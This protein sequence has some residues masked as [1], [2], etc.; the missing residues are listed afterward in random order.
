MRP[1]RQL[2]TLPLKSHSLS[3][4]WLLFVVLVLRGKRP[5]SFFFAF[6]HGKLIGLA[7]P[8]STSRKFCLALT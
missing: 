3:I 5:G 4:V 7:C 1:G 6:K 8:V 2:S